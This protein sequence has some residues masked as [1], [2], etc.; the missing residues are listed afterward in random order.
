M[1]H[2]PCFIARE[3]Y[4]RFLLWVGISSREYIIGSLSNI[5]AAAVDNAQWIYI[6]QAYFKLNLLP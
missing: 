1:T 3:H 4:G 5:A 6:L 2:G